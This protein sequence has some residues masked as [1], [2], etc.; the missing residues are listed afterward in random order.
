M[1]DVVKHMIFLTNKITI[2]TSEK[3]ISEKIG[4]KGLKLKSLLINISRR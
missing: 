4:L 1:V 3:N 2:E